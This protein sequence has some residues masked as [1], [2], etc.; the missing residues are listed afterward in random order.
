MRRAMGDA[1]M[2]TT[3]VAAIGARQVAA[4]RVQ[5]WHSLTGWQEDVVMRGLG[6]TSIP[7][8]RSHDRR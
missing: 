2:A 8:H 4:H 3:A 5:P 6:G 7:G 1:T